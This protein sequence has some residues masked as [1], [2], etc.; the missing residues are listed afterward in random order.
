MLW[1]LFLIVHLIIIIITCIILISQYNNWNEIL[2]LNK[3]AGCLLTVSDNIH[4]KK[5]L[6]SEERQKN[7]NDMILVALE[8]TLSL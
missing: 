7:L 4:T 1:Y 8:S 6:T 5:E 3:K 2:K